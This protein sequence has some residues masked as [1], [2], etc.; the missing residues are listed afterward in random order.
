MGLPQP[1]TDS[2][3]PRLTYSA[4][5]LTLSFLQVIRRNILASPS[6]PALDSSSVAGLA[7]IALAVS[8]N[9]PSASTQQLWLSSSRCARIV[10]QSCVQRHLSYKRGIL[11]FCSMR[12]SLNAK[13]DYHGLQ[14]IL[15]VHL[16]IKCHK[17]S[18]TFWGII[19][20]CKGGNTLQGSLYIG[21]RLSELFSIIFAL[22]AAP[23]RWQRYEFFR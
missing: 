20:P 17:F 11:V 19:N 3:R 7:R 10:V 6:V 14:I 15:Y 12:S 18:A 16:T 23:M 5:R 21:G 9:I 13:P 4:P 2:L 8:V 22:I 1:R